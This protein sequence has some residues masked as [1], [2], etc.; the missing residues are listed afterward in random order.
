[1]LVGHP[2]GKEL[3]AVRVVQQLTRTWLG[4]GLGQDRA[5]LARDIELPEDV[6]QPILEALRDADLVHEGRHAG[7]S[8]ARDPAQ[9]TLGDVAAAL[10]GQG[11]GIPDEPDPS[12]PAPDLA[13]IDAVL[14]AADAEAS[15]RLQSWTWVDLADL[16]RRPPTPKS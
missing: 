15:K 14:L 13:Q 12:I 3:A 16:Q 8:P 1:M 4:Q 10:W 11:L 2:R 9:L 7:W 6:V 5:S